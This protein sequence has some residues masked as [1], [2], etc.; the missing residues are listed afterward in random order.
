M[1]GISFLNPLLLLGALA[2]AVPIALHLLG[3]RSLELYR[4]STLRLLRQIE[5]ESRRRQRFSE[6]LLLLVRVSTVVLLALAAARPIWRAESAVQAGAAGQGLAE[7]FILLDTS[8]SMAQPARGGTALSASLDLLREF[9][10]GLPPSSQV[11]LLPT[12]GQ[13]SL[14]AANLSTEELLGQGVLERVQLSSVPATEAANLAATEAHRNGAARLLL[15]TDG[16]ATTLEALSRNAELPLEVVQLPTTTG[17]NLS[18]AKA[19]LSPETAVLG[20][21]ARLRLLLRGVAGQQGNCVLAGPEGVL[22]TV[23]YRLAGVGTGAASSEV[24]LEWTPAA[25]GSFPLACRCGMDSFPADNLFFTQHEVRGPRQVVTVAENSEG[26]TGGF[27]ELLL[28]PSRRISGAPASP[29]RVTAR[30]WRELRGL[31]LTGTEI[32]VLEDCPDVRLLPVEKLEQFVAQGGVLLFVPGPTLSHFDLAASFFRGT[33]TASWLLPLRPSERRTL[34]DTD[35]PFQLSAE[36]D[37]VG[38]SA[39]S[40]QRLVRV[41][42]GSFSP[43]ELTDRLSGEVLLATARSEPLVARK[44]MGRGAVLQ[45]AFPVNP[46]ESGFLRWPGA[47]PFLHHE[48]LR[49]SSRREFPAWTTTTSAARLGVRTSPLPF[50][51]RE[52]ELPTGWSAESLAGLGLGIGSIAAESGEVPIGV[53]LDPEEGKLEALDS[54]R[55]R[56][57]FPNGRLIEATQ[58]ES[59]AGRVLA[60]PVEPW[61]YVLWGVLLLLVVETLLANPLVGLAQVAAWFTQRE[62]IGGRR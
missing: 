55:F 18:I 10:A 42:L 50:S 62:E 29:F 16:Q 51:T 30:N 58:V 56:E 41:E 15:F 31:D 57:L 26:L 8:P 3:R 11:T 59:G 19:V 33:S 24:E 38:S 53:M 34:Q 6:W 60:R 52:W 25:E 13:G 43:S 32:L 23:P 14:L 22:A 21:P 40:G 44:R 49:L 45:L 46:A 9:L 39:N 12:H 28:D 5:E 20:A 48:L 17:D 1:F 7:T 27:L 35:L 61:R 2:A 54:V 37:F 4:F 36:A 47:L